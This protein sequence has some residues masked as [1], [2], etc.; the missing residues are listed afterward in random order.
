MAIKAP[1]GNGI[2]SPDCS[3]VDDFLWTSNDG[4]GSDCNVYSELS[5]RMKK[6]Y[7]EDYLS[8][9]GDLAKH[10]GCGDGVDFDLECLRQ[11][12]IIDFGC[13][14]QHPEDGP[15]GASFFQPWLCRAL[16]ECGVD[17][18][19]V[20][21]YHPKYRI[22]PG[23]YGEM[24]LGNSV[25]EDWRLVN[26]DLRNGNALENEEP[27]SYDVVNANLLIAHGQLGSQTPSFGIVK[28]LGDEAYLK[29]ENQVFMHAMRLLKPGGVFVVN[30]RQVYQKVGGPVVFEFQDINGEGL[31][32]VS[33]YKF[34][35]ESLAREADLSDV[36]I[37]ELLASV[38]DVCL[39]VLQ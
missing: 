25:I 37:S 17:V 30:Y 4:R 18:T 9:V 19:G 32:G 39:A 2:E 8:L 35:D 33:K 20:D 13:G 28:T 1:V 16:H 24:V 22:P 6:K 12:K 29:F 7:G 3:I 27:N 36:E 14:A 26:A 11:L 21:L 31:S 5:E 23:S 10:I 38:H 15:E 34:V